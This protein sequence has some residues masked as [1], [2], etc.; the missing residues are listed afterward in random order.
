MNI[1]KYPVP[2]HINTNMGKY[3]CKQI[4]TNANIQYSATYK[5]IPQHTNTTPY[6]HKQTQST[7]IC[8]YR[9]TH[10]YKHTNRNI[11]KLTEAQGRRKLF[12]GPVLLSLT[13]KAKSK[14]QN[15]SE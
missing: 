13:V 4:H 14:A 10:K 3:K 8:K 11:H 7:H 15:P 12:T 9:H 5:P 1:N 2:I 6:T